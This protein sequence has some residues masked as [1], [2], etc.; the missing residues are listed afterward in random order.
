MRWHFPKP[1]NFC[2]VWHA[3]D[4][5][6]PLIPFFSPCSS[7]YRSCS[8]Q[9]AQWIP[10][11]K[12]G[13]TACYSA[14]F[15]PGSWMWECLFAQEEFIGAKSLALPSVL[16]NICRPVMGT[17]SVLSF[18]KV[19]ENRKKKWRKYGEYVWSILVLPSFCRV[20]QCGWWSCHHLVSR[21][22]SG[23]DC[24]PM[25]EAGHLRPLS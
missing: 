19:R 2:W 1:D 7:V 13:S 12:L 15:G 20:S 17:V 25:G 3:H 22:A 14:E 16:A 5:W 4:N 21:Q 10:D 18:G 9:L 8:H 6:C 11:F 23:E 24:L